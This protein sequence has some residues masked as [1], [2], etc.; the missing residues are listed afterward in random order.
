MLGGHISAGHGPEVSVLCKQGVGGSSPLVSTTKAAGRWRVDPSSQREASSATRAIR[1]ATGLAQHA[2]S[3]APRSDPPR[4]RSVL[5]EVAALWVAPELADPVGSI[6]VLSIR[7]RRSSARVPARPNRRGRTQ[8][9]E[10]ARL[11]PVLAFSTRMVCRR[12]WIGAPVSIVRTGDGRVV[13][14]R[15]TI[16]RHDRRRCAMVIMRFP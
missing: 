13:A 7:M 11:A 10:V 3:T 9:L 16:V 12:G 15:S 2:A 6:E 4:S 14:G 8:T 5:G 1:S